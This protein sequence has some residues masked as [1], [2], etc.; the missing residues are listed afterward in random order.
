MLVQRGAR[1]RR[2]DKQLLPSFTSGDHIEAANT[3]IRYGGKIEDT[4]RSGRTPLLR[5][6]IEGNTKAVELLL[7]YGASVNTAETRTGWTPLHYAATKGHLEIVQR[8]LQHGANTEV[9]DSQCRTPLAGAVRCYHTRIVQLLLQAGANPNVT[10]I[11]GETLASLAA[12]LQETVIERMILR[13]ASEP[14]RQRRTHLT[15]SNIKPV[16]VQEASRTV[17]SPEDPISSSAISHVEMTS[18]REGGIFGYETE[19]GYYRLPT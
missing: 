18:R 4:D 8:L 15:E 9:A 2:L 19:T 1:F 5:A 17:L 16:S 14:S 10:N 7:K 11:H 13:A 12:R 3:I 6:V